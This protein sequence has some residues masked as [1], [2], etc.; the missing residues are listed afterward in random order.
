M[1]KKKQKP[2]DLK[3]FPLKQQKARLFVKLLWSQFQTTIASSA[4]ACPTGHSM[5]SLNTP[6]KGP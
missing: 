5:K 4:V 1:A 3:I 6:W 2:S